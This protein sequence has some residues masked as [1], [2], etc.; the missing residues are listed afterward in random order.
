MDPNYHTGKALRPNAVPTG[1]DQLA[2][3]T[4]GATDILLAKYRQVRKYRLQNR[5]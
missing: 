2:L 3:L 4:T 5:H 1:I